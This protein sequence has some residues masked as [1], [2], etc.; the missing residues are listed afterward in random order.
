[1]KYRPSNSVTAQKN[2]QAYWKFALSSVLHDIK[3]KH[4]RLT[5]AYIFKRKKDR[6]T[7][8][9]LYTKKCSKGSKVIFSFVFRLKF[10]HLHGIDGVF[11]FFFAAQFKREK[12]IEGIGNRI[13]ISRLDCVPFYILCLFVICV[14]EICGPTSVYLLPLICYNSRLCCCWWWWWLLVVVVG[15]CCCWCCCCCW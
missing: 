12:G 8:M 11:F 13:R 14:T 9:K 10:R 5:A 6:I 7:Y 3:S 1:M 4:N 2:P 15:S